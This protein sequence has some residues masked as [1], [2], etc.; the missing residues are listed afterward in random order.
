MKHLGAVVL[1]VGLVAC[2]K[3]TTT[4]KT[5]VKIEKK[6]DV[7]VEE[8]KTVGP[9]TPDPQ[10]AG[11]L[12]NPNAPLGFWRVETIDGAD[13]KPQSL[14]AM[15]Q[16]QWDG[17]DDKLVYFR[18]TLNIEA[19]KLTLGNDMVTGQKGNAA[20]CSVNT[21][22]PIDLVDN[23]FTISGMASTGAV[24]KS[25][26]KNGDTDTDTNNCNVSLGGATY[27]AEMKGKKLILHYLYQGK[28]S[29]MALVPDD[30]EVDLKAMMK[31]VNGNAS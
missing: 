23:K 12:S 30:A 3:H 15:M 28:E 19:N 11:G 5:E 20:F 7:P 18:M 16:K 21:A 31:S 25:K 22:T 17:G 24:G 2:E 26:T 14:A 10:P 9:T 1:L 8:T 4:S 27:T 6:A 29:S 13:G